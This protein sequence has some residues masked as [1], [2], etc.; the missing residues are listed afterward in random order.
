MKRML[1]FFLLILILLALNSCEH[2]VINP[3]NIGCDPLVF[4]DTSR[5]YFQYY[6]EEKDTLSLVRS[7]VNIAFDTTVADATIESLFT[8]YGLTKKAFQLHGPD[9]K[10]EFKQFG[11]FVPEGK[12][13]EEFF[14]FYGQDTNCGLGNQDLVRYA[15]PIFWAFPELPADSSILI[16]TDEF[17]VRVDTNTT[18]IEEILT[19][20][21]KHQ[22][23]FIG[24]QPYS[25]DILILRVTK[26]SEFDALGMANLYHE[27]DD[28]VWAEPNFIQIIS[29]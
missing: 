4:V 23:E 28:V 5:V 19:I 11:M 6:F 18:T 15:T 8:E 13:P 3:K 25:R 16:L 1:T 27:F 20:N 26:Q 14:T 10:A 24:L 12:R 17:I 9:V 22:I 2:T 29:Q 7:L 21:E